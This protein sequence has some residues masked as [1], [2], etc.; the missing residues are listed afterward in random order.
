[1]IETVGGGV[2]NGGN[3]NALTVKL[4]NAISSLNAGKVNTAVNQ[5]NAFI[6]QVLAFLSA[7]KLTTAQAQPL[8]DGANQAIASAQA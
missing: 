3:G 5:L 8:I 4:N 6:N 7:G 1:M 2:L